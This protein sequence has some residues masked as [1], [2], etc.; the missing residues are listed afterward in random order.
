MSGTKKEKKR[1]KERQEEG[2]YCHMVKNGEGK[3]VDDEKGEKA[4]QKKRK[5]NALF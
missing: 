1:E 2:T 4:R 5:A 3:K